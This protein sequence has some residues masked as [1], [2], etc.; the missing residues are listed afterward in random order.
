VA[1]AVTL[2]KL[3]DGVLS[4]ARQPVFDQVTKLIR[5]RL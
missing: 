3:A 1:V 5:A 2:P 4:E